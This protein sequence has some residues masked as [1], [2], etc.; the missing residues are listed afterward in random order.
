MIQRAEITRGASSPVKSL[1]P[2]VLASAMLA[3]RVMTGMAFMA[4]ALGQIKHYGDFAAACAALNLPSGRVFCVTSIIINFLGAV[5]LLL[6]FYP[7]VGAALL[8]FMTAAVLPFLFFTQTN[9]LVSAAVLAI[10]GGLIPYIVAGGGE[11]GLGKLYG[12]AG[13][14]RTARKRGISRSNRSL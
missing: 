3:G 10:A 1:Y 12:E 14:R 9:M 6:G 4:V 13:K 11:F 7:R 5:S 2:A 8:F